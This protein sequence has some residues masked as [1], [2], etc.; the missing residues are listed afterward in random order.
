MLTSNRLALQADI[1]SLDDDP[2]ASCLAKRREL[3]DKWYKPTAMLPFIIFLII[4][5]S[6]F[7]H[8]TGWFLTSIGLATVLWAG[9]VN[10]Y[11][12]YLRITFRCPKCHNRFGSGENC[13]SCALPKHPPQRAEDAMFTSL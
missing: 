12:L 8:S 6:F 7:M 2:T 9:G 10:I 4:D 1:N 13:L 5:F 11:S 3:L